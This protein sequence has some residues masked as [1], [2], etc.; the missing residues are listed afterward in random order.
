MLLQVYNYRL[1]KKKN[2]MKKI[3]W[4]PSIDFFATC[5]PFHYGYDA[6]LNVYH[7]C[8][9][10]FRPQQVDP[11]ADYDFFDPAFLSSS[12][13]LGVWYPLE[14]KIANLLDSQP[15]PVTTSDEDFQKLAEPF[16]VQ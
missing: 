16:S 14:R 2:G 5:Y 15:K 9:A 13:F 10:F 6:D 11:S 8:F 1:N 7:F 3:G 4:F 12:A